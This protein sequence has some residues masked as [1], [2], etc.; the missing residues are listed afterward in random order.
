V[1]Y[2]ADMGAADAKRAVDAAAEALPAWRALSPAARSEIL[3]KWREL[4]LANKRAIA[5]LITAEQGKPL[6][7]AIAEVEYGASFMQWYAEE[8]RRIYGETIP[9]DCANR[10]FMVIKQP[11]GVCAAIAPWNFPFAII[12]R[13]A[14]PA[15]AA[16]CTMVVKP[17]EQ[18][19]LS[20][21]TIA[22]LAQEAGVPAGVLNVVPCLDPE[23]VGGELCDNPKVRKLSFTGSTPVGKRLLARAAATVKKVTLELG[24]QTP[25]IIFD[26]ADLGE[27]LLGAL[28]SKF[29]NAGQTC[30]CANRFFVQESVY[31]EFARMFAD[32]VSQLQVGDG[33]QPTSKVGPLIDQEALTKVERHVADA[34]A[35]G[36]RVLVG[37]KRHRLG[38]TFFEPTVLADVT[39]TMAV[40]QEET[41]GPIAALMKFRDEDEAVRLANDTRYGLAAYV[42]TRDIGRVWRVPEALEFGM[43]GV[44]TSGFSTPTAPLGGIK[45]SGL[46]REGARQGL[47]Q[48]LEEKYLCLGGIAKV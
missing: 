29:R 43:V 33:M 28:A 37:G 38:G 18:A 24:G 30:V 15:L 8:G 3:L 11:V 32:E 45:E 36:A 41:F 40:A 5:E 27:A 20:A 34:V 47:E 46:G 21:L 25:F 12:V 17:A 35:R 31:D 22:Q 23:G 19:P 4:T 48:Y 7:E 16:G 44:N 2:A 6:H 26:D 39:P 10:R 14:A 9:A 42:Y 13:K 1:G